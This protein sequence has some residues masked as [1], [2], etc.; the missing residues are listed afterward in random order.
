MNSSAEMECL[1]VVAVVCIP[2]GVSQGTSIS[3]K[4]LHVYAL[5]TLQL[6]Q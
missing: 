2:Q 1:V 5:D 3:V 6:A 4:L